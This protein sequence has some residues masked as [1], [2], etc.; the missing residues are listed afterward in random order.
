MSYPK[1]TNSKSASV[2]V[3]Y[4]IQVNTVRNDQIF[5]PAKRRNIRKIVTTYHSR[6][7]S[8]Y[9]TRVILTNSLLVR[10]YSETTMVP[11]FVAVGSFTQS[12]NYYT[13]RGLGNASKEAIQRVCSNIPHVVLERFLSVLAYLLYGSPWGN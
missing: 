4:L 7:L 9:V 2:E 3:Y 11:F 12:D 5:T 10:L 8:L 6:S 1:R 13:N